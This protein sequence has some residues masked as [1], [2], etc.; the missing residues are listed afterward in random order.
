MSLQPSGK[1]SRGA[2]STAVH[3]GERLATGKEI[4]SSSPIHIATAYAYETA[5]DLDAVFS[6]N[7]LGYV[8]SRYG[9]PTVRG[10]EIA[11]AALEGTEEAVAYASGMA[12]IFGAITETTHPGQSIVI[13]RDVYGA[14]FSLVQDYLSTND[15]IAHFVDI[16]D[17]ETVAQVVDSVQPAAI[18]AETASNP[19]IRVAD[20]PALAAIAR[21][22]GA[23]LVIDNTF[24]SPVLVQPASLGADLVV[25]SATKFLG[26]HGDATGG[27]V[28]TSSR[29]A[30]GLRQNQKLTGAILSPFDAWLTHRGIKTL[31]LRMKQHCANARDVVAWLQNDTRI[32]TV[33]YPGVSCAL[34]DGQF[35][36]GDHGSMLSFEIHNAGQAA[37]FRFLDALQ[38]VTP[39]PTLGDVYSLTLYPAMSSHRAL[40]PEQRAGIGIG[41][42][43][44]R[45]SVGIEDVA[46]IIDDLD[47]A[48]AAAVG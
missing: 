4:P 26:G 14:T 45:L 16:L 15:I 13:S 27:V 20:I 25:H 12:A 46:D 24:V 31:P 19:L 33:Y 7:S 32:D 5:A 34:P 18:L 30:A 44:V 38:L 36:T 47:Q 6:D 37:V 23:K 28:A 35:R 42:N 8:Y 10:L 11:I 21:G 48:L 39:A 40:T 29:H 1:Y 9:N 3:A 2:A 17:L 22:A 43:L 41:D